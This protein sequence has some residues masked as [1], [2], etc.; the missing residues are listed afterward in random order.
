VNFSGQVV[1][2]TGAGKGLGRAYAEHLAARGAAV[3][4]NNRRHPGETD[5]E[6]SAAGTVAAIR[7]AGGR[8]EANH[9]DVVA[10][11]AGHDMVQQALRQFGRLDALVC[12][13]GVSRAASFHNHSVE[14][15]RRVF[16]A[17]FLGHLH[18][19]HAA[20]PLMRQA[21][22]GRIVA[23]T[24][25]AGLHGEHGMSACASAKAAVIGLMRS[26][27]AEGAQAGITINCISPYAAAQSTER[28]LTAAESAAFSAA[29]VAPLVTWLASGACTLSGETIVAGGGGYRR[30]RS[31]ESETL[32]TGD[33]DD[34]ALGALVPTL[35]ELETPHHYP[36]ASAAFAALLEE[37]DLRQA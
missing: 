35:A 26:L 11:D 13:A 3:I 15:F 30:A 20:W 22:Y 19:I 31:G 5:E 29:R 36:V 25:G 16:D 7:A 9:A 1:I 23:T 2:V 32:C 24:S 21:R 14:D 4:V 18:L 27:A 6:T 34:A 17:G 28:Y 37:L 8:A 33:V 12:N 10:P